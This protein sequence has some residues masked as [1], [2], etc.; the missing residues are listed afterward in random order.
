VSRAAKKNKNDPFG[1][2]TAPLF[3]WYYILV[4]L[5]NQNPF[6][7]ALVARVGRQTVTYI[8][9]VG[10]GEG[11]FD[12]CG[13]VFIFAPYPSAAYDYCKT[14]E[15]CVFVECREPILKIRWDI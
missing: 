10:I 15:N 2:C 1:E 14:H 9:A 7:A 11:A 3:L 5:W 8:D 12:A 13:T 6:P 4:K